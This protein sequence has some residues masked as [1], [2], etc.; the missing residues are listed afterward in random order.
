M[1]N[2]YSRAKKK[3]TTVQCIT[4]QYLGRATAEAVGHRLHR[5]GEHLVSLVGLKGPDV[6]GVVLRDLPTG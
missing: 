5:R 4:E 1:L 6:E 2:K 3:R